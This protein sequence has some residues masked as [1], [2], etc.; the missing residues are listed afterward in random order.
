MQLSYPVFRLFNISVGI[1]TGHMRKN[2]LTGLTL[3]VLAAF[4]LNCA[5][6][7]TEKEL[8]GSVKGKASLRLA[9][10]STISRDDS[11]EY[12]PYIV[13]LSD[14]YLV[15]VFGSNRACG[16]CSGHNIFMA[17]SLTP[18]TPYELPFFNT[19]VVVQNNSTL[20]NAPSPI[21]FAAMADSANVKLYVNLHSVTGFVRE[22]TVTNPNAPNITPALAAI[23]N[24][25]HEANTIVGVSADG[26]KLISTDFNQDVY[27]FDPGS[28]TSESPFGFN[29]SMSESVI[30]V[31]F[32]N[33]GFN[34][35]YIG[36]FFGTSFAATQD[37]YFGPIIDLDISVA[38]SG[39]FM[40]G[41]TTFY[42]DSAAEDLVLFTANDGF[43]DD[44]YVIT[45]H[46]AADLWN[47]AGFFG[48]DSFLPPAPTPDHWYTFDSGCTTDSGDPGTWTA[49]ACTAITPTGGSYNGSNYAPFNGTS[50]RLNI[51]SV[52]TGAEFTISAWVYVPIA[53]TGNL[54]IASNTNAAADSDG[55][56]LYAV[57]SPDFKLVFETGDGGGPSSGYTVN[58]FDSVW[59]PDTWY[60]VVV[61][62]NSNFG[63]VDIYVNGNPVT[64][65]FPPTIDT[66]YT[67]TGAGSLF[68]GASYDSFNFFDGYMDDIKI[69]SYAIS[70]PEALALYLE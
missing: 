45:S 13:K 40:G 24:T 53:A 69:F 39:L 16:G 37:I 49:A 25:A 43:S 61:S 66:A 14:N 59:T 2:L 27:I 29:L 17:K 48:G 31:R 8:K 20:I 26:G 38:S 9:D 5:P 19:P 10:G 46:T 36:T 65:T 6:R 30:Q 57:S 1:F 55:F 35:S 21:S 23:T 70:P 54:M 28:G 60:H 64:F 12:N 50:S 11:D 44:M 18:Y 32:D 58:S 22:G 7:P 52:D 47:I 68:F 51:G 33:T 41:L 56:K 4:A 3:A 34:D 63:F 62:A 15:L 42:G 67:T